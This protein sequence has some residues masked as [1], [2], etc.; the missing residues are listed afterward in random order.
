VAKLRARRLLD[1]FSPRPKRRRRHTL[2]STDR[3]DNAKSMSDTD[4]ELPPFDQVNS[5]FTVGDLIWVKFRKHPFWPALVGS[6]FRDELTMIM[7]IQWFWSRV[8]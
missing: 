3:L 4:E 2:T 7:T 8:S 1:A 6:G 5:S